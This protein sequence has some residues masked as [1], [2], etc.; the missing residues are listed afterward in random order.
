[1][2][3]NWPALAIPIHNGGLDQGRARWL[4]AY[5]EQSSRERIW[6]GYLAGV[7]MASR[8]GPVQRAL[9]TSSPVVGLENF[10]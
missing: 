4:P 1:M 5:A 10:R 7:L 6:T 3:E 9:V 2:G 8:V